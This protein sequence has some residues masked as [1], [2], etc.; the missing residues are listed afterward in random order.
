MSAKETG[1]IGAIE[2]GE[3]RCVV[4]KAAAKFHMCMIQALR[5]HRLAALG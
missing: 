4:K 3:E 2:G 1:S 5:L